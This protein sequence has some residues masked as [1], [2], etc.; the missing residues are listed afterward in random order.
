MKLQC[1]LCREIV[2]ADFAVAGDGIDVHCPACEKIFRVGATRG[3]AVVELKKPRPAPPAG[4]QA[5]TCPKCE[6][7]QPSAP[8]CR[9]CGLLASRMADFV[10]DRDSRVA[11]EVVAAWQALD[12]AW[13]DTE[14]HDRFIKIVA[15][16]MAYPWAARRYREAL[17]LRPDDRLAAEQLARLARMAEATLFASGTKRAEAKPKA[18][19]GALTL[20]AAMLILVFVGLGYAILT[21][22][23]QEDPPA[24]AP[25]P[26]VQKGPKPAR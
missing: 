13:S 1:D 9:S 19:R 24:P 20:L 7:V 3:A 23:L 5:M 2:A 17:R 11:P 6:D 22:N 15:S 26:P 21:R 18:Y 16:S 12:A 10:R 8:A 14:A 4:E 25:A